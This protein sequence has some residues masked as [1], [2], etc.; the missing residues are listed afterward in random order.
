MD[1]KQI[2]KS[3]AYSFSVMCALILFDIRKILN[4]LYHPT[5]VKTI[6]ISRASKGDIS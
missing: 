6:K 5:D 4:L 2:D 1:V 3:D